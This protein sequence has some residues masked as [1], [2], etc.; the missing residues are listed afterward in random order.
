MLL[1]LPSEAN[2]TTRDAVPG[3]KVIFKAKKGLNK[4]NDL[5][6]RHK[7]LSRPANETSNEA[8]GTP[9][10]PLMTFGVSLTPFRF[11]K[12]NKPVTEEQQLWAQ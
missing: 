6:A 2:S 7:Q 9:V 11:S 3:S 8:S 5:N 12:K 10:L 1:L 4:I